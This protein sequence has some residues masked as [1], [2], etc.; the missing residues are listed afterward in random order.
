MST[1]Y[2]YYAFSW[3]VFFF[4]FG[5]DSNQFQFMSFQVSVIFANMHFHKMPNYENPR[6]CS[7]HI[8]VACWPNYHFFC[9]TYDIIQQNNIFQS[10]FL[11]RV[12]HIKVKILFSD[13]SPKD[14]TFWKSKEL[15]KLFKLS[16]ALMLWTPNSDEIKLIFFESTF[17]WILNLHCSHVNYWTQ[18]RNIYLFCLM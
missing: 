11:C 9:T 2:C 12:F 16:S 13:I 7:Y 17:W 1:F 6:K 3:R 15:F 18:N 14:I 5:W 10:V 8:H 4:F